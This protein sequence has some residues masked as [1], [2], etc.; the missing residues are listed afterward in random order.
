VIEC[1]KINILLSQSQTTAILEN[2]NYLYYEQVV[3]KSQCYKMGDFVYIKQR[4]NEKN[5]LILADLTQ[6]PVEFDELNKGVIL[7]IDRLWRVR[8]PNDAIQQNK[9]VDNT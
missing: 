4:L 3:Y 2:E 7:R 6:L 1:K 9:L 5:E 8:A